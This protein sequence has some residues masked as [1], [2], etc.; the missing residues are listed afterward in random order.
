MRIQATMC[1]HQQPIFSSSR[2]TTSLFAYLLRI[3]AL[4][5]APPAPPPCR[6][7][8]RFIFSSSD[9]KNVATP[10]DSV[11]PSLLGAAVATSHKWSPLGLM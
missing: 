8:S 2:L 11:D 10:S 6:P 4:P 3:T 1:I 9:K 7:S 5:D